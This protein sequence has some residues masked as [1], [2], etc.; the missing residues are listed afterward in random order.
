MGR[1]L[2]F[3]VTEETKKKISIG[4]KGKNKG[5][6]SPNLGKHLSTESKIKIALAN[7][8]RI[9]SDET[10]QKM[11]ESKRGE[12][13]S[14]YK[15]RRVTGDNY[16]LIF[17]ADHPYRNVANCVQEHRLVME[18]ELGRYLEPVEV[19]H[20]INKDTL[21]NRLENLMLFDNNAEHS[22][23][24]KIIRRGSNEYLC[25]KNL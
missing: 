25:K 22:K 2:G 20:H 15:G 14:R 21:D 12:N 16:V 9:F 18:K 4:N 8:N 7:R 24:H 19:V 3:I 10:K 23:Y 1:P 13:N 17:C 5:K 6:Q 11:S